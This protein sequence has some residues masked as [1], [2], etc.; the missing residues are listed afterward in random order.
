MVVLKLETLHFLGNYTDPQSTSGAL[1]F[2]SS[3]NGMLVA[4]L[5]SE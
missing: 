4:I 2:G 3:Q 1:W 5:V